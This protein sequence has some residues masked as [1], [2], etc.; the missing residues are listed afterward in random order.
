MVVICDTIYPDESIY[1]EHFD[2]FPYQLS[3][4]QKYSIHAV[5]EG[6]HSL[7]TAHTGTGKSVPAEFAIQYFTQKGKKVIYTSPIKALSNQKYHDFT[8]KYPKISFGIMTGD[9]KVNPDAD[10][11][12]MTTEILMNYLF[13]LNKT[14]EENE[15]KNT[16]LDFQIDIENELACVVFDEIHYINDADRGHVWEKTIL[17]LPSHIQMIMLSATIDK[18]EK[19]AGW[20]ETIHKNKQ[21]Y[22]SYTN[23]RIVP[24]THYGY[25]ITNESIFKKI[26]DKETQQKIRDKTNKLISLKDENGI[27]QETGYFDIKKMKQLFD[28]N[29][30]MVKRQHVLNNLTLYLRE[31][32]MLPAIAFVFSRK[33]VEL[34]AKEIT[35]P[36]LEDDSK[37]SY[38]VRREC[39]QIIRKLPNYQEYLD[40]PEYNELITLLERGIGI[41]HS[42]MI[43]VLREIVE[44]MISKKYIKLLFATESFAIGLN[45]PIRTAI[46][47]SLTKYDGNGRRFL[48]AHEYNQAAS[49]CG[50][51]GID[52][53]GHVVHCNNLFE[54]PSMNEY[55]ELLC[56]KPQTLVSKFHISFSVILNL[57]K[58]GK[59]NKSDFYDFV[60]KSMVQSEI[61]NSIS[62]QKEIINKIKKEYEKKKESIKYL[63]TPLEVCEKY[64]QNE[65]LLP[66]SVNKKRK[67]IQRII[68]EI[69]IDYKNCPNDSKEVIKLQQLKI[70]YEREVNYMDSIESYINTNVD[71]ICNILEDYGFIESLENVYQFTSKGKISSCISEIHPLIVGNIIHTLEK[72]TSVE[73]VGLLSCFTDIKV[74]SDIKSS[75]PNTQNE[76][77]KQTINEI[78]IQFTLYENLEIENNLNTGF[79]YDN[80]MVFDVIDDIQEWCNCSDEIECKKFIQTRLADKQISVGD[81]TKSILKISNISKELMNACNDNEMMD[82]YNKLYRI[83]SL[84]LKYI[85]TAQ[86]LYV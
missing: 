31:R 58:N 70:D 65:N 7:V 29:E 34:Y 17:M 85:A 19:F 32:D 86:S 62:T 74:D 13:T 67:E 35:T 37:V 3:D 42:G 26:K 81:F 38:T 71:T 57:I 55:K 83:D 44:L 24:L 41:H 84:I 28:N 72:Y 48:M 21:V 5:I 61:Q 73:L 8:Q 39:E 36:L 15:I 56:G 78:K 76:T 45:C 64:I 25:L 12:I 80:C 68:E 43:P 14:N 75:V 77:L 51:R 30:I 50:R 49:R 63:R 53:I 6:N 1:N 82:L 2:L 4:F 27:F 40:L 66:T 69:I 33:N 20:C 9:I 16:S 18:P 52:T 47:T 23:T 60:K 11:L 46:F 10:V 79:N 59:T 54:Y 22:L